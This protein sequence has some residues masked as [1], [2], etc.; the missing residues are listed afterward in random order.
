MK[1]S[2]YIE[3]SLWS[4]LADPPSEPKRWAT[5]AFLRSTRLGHRLLVSPI[6]IEEILET[7]DRARAQEIIDRLWAMR[8]EVLP[9]WEEAERIASDLIAA[10]RWS[11]R[12][13]ADL[14]HVGYTVLSRADA[15]VTWDTDD[16]A[17]PRP[18]TVVHA[19]A[20]RRGMSAPL[21]GTPKEVAEWLDI[22]T[23]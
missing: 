6:V 15:L 8:P 5:E 10:G 19:Y 4:R 7:P 21:I 12:R 14:V 1:R 17:R 18:R 3:T 9:A 13:I 20:R 2:L 22:R 11:R 23:R 16:L